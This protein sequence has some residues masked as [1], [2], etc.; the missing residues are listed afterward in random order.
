LSLELKEYHVDNYKRSLTEPELMKDIFLDHLSP[1]TVWLVRLARNRM[2][3]G[4][5]FI[6]I[7]GS[8]C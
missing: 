8:I 1:V 4:R 5:E 7:K 2:T 6:P 3:I